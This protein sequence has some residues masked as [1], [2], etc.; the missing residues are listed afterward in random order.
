MRTSGRAR[1]SRVL[2]V[3][4]V[5]VTL[6]SLNLVSHAGSVS[7]SVNIVNNSSREIRNVYPAPVGTDDWGGNLLNGAIAAGQSFTLN[8][9]P[10]DSQQIK[11]VAEDQDGCFITTVTSCGQSSTWTLTNESARDC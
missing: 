4:V 5:L 11:L 1:N 7:T 10:C 3:S 6:T 2:I 8:N 9:V